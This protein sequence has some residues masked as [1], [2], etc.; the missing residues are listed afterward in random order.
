MIS[1]PF[2]EQN[3]ID[4]KQQENCKHFGEYNSIVFNTP[5]L[6]IT[7][8]LHIH[9]LLMQHL[10]VSYIYLQKVSMSV[11]SSFLAVKSKNSESFDQASHLCQSFLVLVKC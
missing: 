5:I 3:T 2:L 4:T 10:Q 9:N 1:Q 8:L 6:H 11:S 7:I